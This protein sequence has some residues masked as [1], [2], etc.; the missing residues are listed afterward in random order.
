MWTSFVIFLAGG[1]YWTIWR[2]GLDPTTLWPV[3]AYNRLLGGSFFTI[4]EVY[5]S[6]MSVLA[7][8]TRIQDFLNSPEPEDDR[9]IFKVLP[10]DAAATPEKGASE[11]E[12]EN[13]GPAI[14]L[15]G[16]CVKAK[17]DE[18]FV[19][20]DVTFEIPTSALALVVGTVGSGKSVLLK[21]IMGEARLSSG[22]IQLASARLAFCDQIPWLSF[23]SIR[24]VIVGETPWDEARYKEV[25]GACALGHDISRFPSGDA[26]VVG[27]NGSGLSGGQKQRVVSER[28]GS[29]LITYQALFLT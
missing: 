16:V 2:D 29:S 5:P 8:I 21:T 25:V 22:N 9:E 14:R 4:V 3:V 17:D 7:C 28:K 23:M 6:I 24:D 26:T 1:L 11:K 15:S 10:S 12:S 20:D 27:A 19:L 18:H 13:S